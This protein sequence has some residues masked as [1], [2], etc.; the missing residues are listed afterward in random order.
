MSGLPKNH[1]EISAQVV[2]EKLKSLNP[3]LVWVIESEILHP[4]ARLC[5]ASSRDNTKS[6][7]QDKIR[8]NGGGD[9]VFLLDDSD[10]AK[11]LGFNQS[12]DNG[13]M[14]Q[15]LVD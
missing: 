7:H 15:R 2:V 12:L 11:A 3:I 9:S 5:F 14:R 10:V 13:V 6:I 8:K 4:G 1:F